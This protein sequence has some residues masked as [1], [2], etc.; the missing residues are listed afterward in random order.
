ML[1]N[2]GKSS[3]LKGDRGMKEKYSM[4][5]FVFA[6]LACCLLAAALITGCGGG[7]N[8]SGPSSS[9]TA[10]AAF[11]N[12]P[13]NATGSVTLN[14]L[15]VDL[16]TQNL[17]NS[18]DAEIYVTI[19]YIGTTYKK[20]VAAVENRAFTFFELPEGQYMITV[21]DK[22]GVY[23]PSNPLIQEFSAGKVNLTV[24][25]S[26]KTGTATTSTLNFFATVLDASLK[27][28]IMFA[29]V[30]V[31]IENINNLTFQ[32]TTIKTG[33]FSL[34][35]LA[36]GTYT[37]KISKDG[38]VEV[39]KTLIIS[40]KI[41]F[42][43][44]EI[45]AADIATFKDGGGTSRT[46]YYLGELLM[47]PKFTNTGGLAGILLD[48]NKNPIPS[49]TKLD[50][51]YLKTPKDPVGP[52]T[53]IPNVKPNVLGYV[54]FKNLPAGEYV[55]AEANDYVTPAINWTASATY[56]ADGN[57]SG[58]AFTPASK[59]VTRIWLSVTPGLVTP[60]PEQE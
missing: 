5:R 16:T 13:A 48:A 45:V 14:G 37:V 7:N 19:E 46:G 4:F 42:G 36:S 18:P 52:G 34:L 35:G 2:S 32:A 50:L 55:L 59:L 21:E 44:Q 57:I 33:E 25:L 40:D 20:T 24:P 47:S 10:A 12:F 31:T 43:N 11:D 3:A 51:I 28:P 39:S 17:I 60:I 49:T 30:D 1:V 41:M 29:T 23:D 27:N 8:P 54:S 38:Y 9:T 22:G 53:I 58:W 56:D 26:P 15:L 6:S